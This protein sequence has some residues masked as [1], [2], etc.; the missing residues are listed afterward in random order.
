MAKKKENPLSHLYAIFKRQKS[1]VFTDHHSA[2]VD[3]IYSIADSTTADHG[4]DNAA[5]NETIH[6]SGT[7]HVTY[8]NNYVTQE[9]GGH[10]TAM[11]PLTKPM[12][13]TAGKHNCQNLSESMYDS[14]LMSACMDHNYEDLSP[15]GY[16][17]KSIL[18]YLLWPRLRGVTKMKVFMRMWATKIRMG[19]IL[20]FRLQQSPCW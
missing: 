11:K 15:K 7:R 12:P 10:K 14:G 1:Q 13:V 5:F 3:E 18:R 6:S 20:Q 4:V 9:I 19:L 8:D 17:A 2:S 16:K